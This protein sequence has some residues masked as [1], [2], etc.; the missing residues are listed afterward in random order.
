MQAGV[1]TM[2]TIYAAWT[3]GAQEKDTGAIKR[4]MDRARRCEG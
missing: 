1:Q 3:E 2:L 4:A